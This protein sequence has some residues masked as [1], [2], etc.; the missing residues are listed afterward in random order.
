VEKPIVVLIHQLCRECW[1]YAFH[2]LIQPIG[3][4]IE[5]ALH[6]IYVKRI[7]K[8]KAV[9]TVSEST[10]RDLIALGYPPELIHIVYNGIDL[11]RYRRCIGRLEKKN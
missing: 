10:R 1:S 8:I 5:K 11:K 7:N 2:P 4:G 3:W 6:K 9:I